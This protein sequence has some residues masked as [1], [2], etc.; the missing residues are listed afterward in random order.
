MKS[1]LTL[2]CCCCFSGNVLWIHPFSSKTLTLHHR[3]VSPPSSPSIRSWFLKILTQRTVSRTT[4]F[5]ALPTW[6]G[7]RSATASACML[8]GERSRRQFRTQTLSQGLVLLPLRCCE[9]N[10]LARIQVYSLPFL[11]AKCRDRLFLGLHLLVVLLPTGLTVFRSAVQCM[12]AQS[13]SFLAVKNLQ[14]GSLK[15]LKWEGF[16]ICIISPFCVDY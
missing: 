13:M 4:I 10:I 12:I 14:L 2:H 1:L 15:F 8:R 6:F 5:A 7:P 16:L 11:I 3:F 9:N